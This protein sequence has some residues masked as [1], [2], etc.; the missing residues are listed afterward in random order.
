MDGTMRNQ[1]R[2]HR[3]L[4]NACW[5]AILPLRA[6]LSYQATFMWFAT[7]VVGMMVRSEL[8]GVTSIVRA[9]SLRPNHYYS[10]RKNFHSTAIEL[11]RPT[12]LWAQAVLRIFTN[13]IRVNGQN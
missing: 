6:A 2:P 1:G 13:P 11:G 9:L 10:L 4:W 5:C 3:T 8:R 7:I 12:V